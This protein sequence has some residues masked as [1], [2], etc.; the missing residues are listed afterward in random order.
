[1]GNKLSTHE[2]YDVGIQNFRWKLGRGDTT[3]DT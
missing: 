3:T 2:I 1:M